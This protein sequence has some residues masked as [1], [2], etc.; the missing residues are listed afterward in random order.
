MIAP[1]IDLIITK[2]NA[3]IAISDLENVCAGEMSSRIKREFWD[4]HHFCWMSF[5]P[6]GEVSLAFREYSFLE[7]FSISLC[8]ACLRIY[9]VVNLEGV[10]D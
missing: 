1:I 2:F 7:N 6:F 10:Y 8:G 9:F 3:H 5:Q 4:T